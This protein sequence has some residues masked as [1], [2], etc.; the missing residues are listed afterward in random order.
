MVYQWRFGE[1]LAHMGY[2]PCPEPAPGAAGIASAAAARARSAP[3]PHG[4]PPGG[5]A[6]AAAVAGVLD[7]S[8]P[9]WGHAAALRYS[10]PGGGRFVGIGEGGLVAM[11]RADVSGPGGLG[12]AD[13]THHVSGA[14]G[15]V[16]RELDG[17]RQGEGSRRRGGA[18]R[19]WL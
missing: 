17:G 14:W 10:S 1:P 2:A 3:G 8:P 16:G 13:W 4:G 11:W 12:Y 5:G 15:W 18:G 6:V 9:H 7:L 19:A